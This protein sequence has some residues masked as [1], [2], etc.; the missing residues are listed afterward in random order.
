VAS[1]HPEPG[2]NSP[3]FSI[4]LFSSS[5]QS[6]D[7]TETD[8]LFVAFAERRT[9]HCTRPED[10][11]CRPAD[12]SALNAGLFRFFLYGMEIDRRIISPPLGS[13]RLLYYFYRC[14]SFNVLALDQGRSPEK[15]CK[16][17]AFFHSIQIFIPLLTVI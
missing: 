13:D 17:T 1:V 6:N 14:N 10:G 9:S 8:L 7:A 5:F 2:S 15:R 3:L 16:G 11:A 4:V 12:M